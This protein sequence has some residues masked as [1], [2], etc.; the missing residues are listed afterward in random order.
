MGWAPDTVKTVGERCVKSIAS[1]LWYLDPQHDHFKDRSL[2]ITGP[3]AKFKG[4]NDWRRK[5]EKRPQIT[6][7]ELDR[8]VQTL[9]SI[10]SQPWSHK[11]HFKTL[12]SEVLSLVEVMRK[13]CCYLQ[14]HNE[15]MKLAHS[16]LLPIRQVEENI[17]LEV[18]SSVAKCD[19]QYSELQ[20]RLLSLPLYTPVFVN[21]FS[22]SDR[23]IYT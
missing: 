13:Y 2:E 16:S 4:Y 9:S 5:K 14:K 23:F 1:T 11:P 10:L 18:R 7:T 21:E 8:H 17:L 19:P 12:H 22:P 3:F 6:H 15:S 20:Q